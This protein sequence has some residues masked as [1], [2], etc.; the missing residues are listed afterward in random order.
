MSYK[1]LQKSAIAIGGS[2]LVGWILFKGLEGTDD[3]IY[4]K[5]PEYKDPSM[6]DKNGLIA[7]RLMAGGSTDLRVLREE[8][9]KLREKIAEE[10][11]T[12]NVPVQRK[13][14]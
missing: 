5:F 4:K 14:G 13:T 7:K 1:I 9:T 6:Y 3:D 10:N 2:T 8:T 11:T 12:Y